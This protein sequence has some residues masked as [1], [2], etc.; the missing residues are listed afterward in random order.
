MFE[1]CGSPCTETCTNKPEICITMCKSGCFCK[2][3]YIRESNENGSPCIQREQCPAVDDHQCGETEEYHECGS[4]CPPMCED[5]SYPLPKPLKRCNKECVRGCFC[6][7]GLYR[8]NDGKCVK[9]Q[10]C[11]GEN[12]IFT[13]CGSACVETCQK[14][15]Q[16]CTEQCVA[17]CF[18]RWDHVRVNNSTDSS[19]IPHNQCSQ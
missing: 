18:C 5:W 10:Q 11:C 17:G 8:T 15:P 13:D 16:I 3:G 6:K 9:P 7:G 12:E 1:T 4:A 2:E 14:K 19:C